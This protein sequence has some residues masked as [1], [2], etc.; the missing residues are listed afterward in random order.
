MILGVIGI[1]IAIYL[2]VGYIALALI[3]PA[4]PRSREHMMLLGI[5]FFPV[6][7]VGYLIY[8]AKHGFRKRTPDE[9]LRKWDDITPADPGPRKKK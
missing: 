9:L 5:Y 1:V 2:L 7:I 6:I 3:E 8:F 4:H